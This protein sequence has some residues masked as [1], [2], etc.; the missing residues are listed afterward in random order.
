MFKSR[1]EK[2]YEE[3]L[4]N[5]HNKAI[6][7]ED[8]M[9]KNLRN[10][11]I[12]IKNK[13]QSKGFILDLENNIDKTLSYQ[14]D[15]FNIYI[16]KDEYNKF[17]IE[18]TDLNYLKFISLVLDYNPVN[19]VLRVGQLIYHGENN[20][21]IINDIENIQDDFNNALNEYEKYIE[22]LYND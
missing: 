16:K 15:R 21:N 12:R 13:C 4:L 22:G 14:L 3:T 7:F 10:L 18:F 11:F 19:D 2:E 8:D 9:I 5:Y 1:K 6:K 17:I 20:I